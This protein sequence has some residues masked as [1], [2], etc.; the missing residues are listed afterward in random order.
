MGLQPAVYSLFENPEMTAGSISMLLDKQPNDQQST[1]DAVLHDPEAV[2]TGYAEVQLAM[3]LNW[4]SQQRK[5]ILL[6]QL[7]NYNIG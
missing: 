6:D 5:M 4:D 1:A 3:A 2:F 7:S